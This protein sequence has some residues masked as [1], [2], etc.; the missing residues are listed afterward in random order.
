[1]NT[2]DIPDAG[3]TA[4]VPASY[5][6]MT[7]PQLLYTM[8]L[9]HD[10]QHGRI[11]FAEFQTRVLYKLA[12]IKRTARSIVWERL[13]PDAT[14]AV[15][16]KVALLADRLLGF[17]FTD[18]GN[19]RLPAFN[20]LENPLPVLRIGPIR[21]VGPAD[22]L[23]DLSFEELIAADAELALYTETH[24]E[25]HI[26]TMIA[27]LYRRRGPM[28]PSGRKVQPFLP[29]KIDRIVRLVRF[30]PAWKKQLVLLWYT[31]CIDNLQHGIFTVCGREVSFAPLFSSS[32]SSGKSLG[33][34]G[35]QFDLA[36]KRTFGDMEKTGK[37]NVIDILT[38]LLNYKYTSDNAKKTTTAD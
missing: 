14:H 34:L 32:E 13:H 24:D 6:E 7:R 5:A 28:Q 26:D 35:I 12:N 11:S 10:L 2:L 4:R 29:E 31:A 37:T 23:L 15:A 9:L 33:W 38:L 30:V 18:N 17:L 20:L 1:M 22:G 27:I 3:I 8:R 25:R 36:E 16:E 21:L 19:T